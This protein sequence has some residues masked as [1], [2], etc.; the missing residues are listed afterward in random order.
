MR[1]SSTT[2]PTWETRSWTRTAPSSRSSSRTMTAKC[3]ETEVSRPA[4]AQHN[5]WFEVQIQNWPPCSPKSAAS[6]TTRSLWSWSVRWGNT[7]TTRTKTTRTSTTLTWT[8]WSCVTARTTAART[9][10]VARVSQPPAARLCTESTTL[11]HNAP[12]TG[13]CVACRTNQQRRQQEVS[14]RQDL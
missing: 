10:W 13:V 8:R 11:L 6:S 2:Y 1:R 5:F 3:T 12:I 9:G 7:A 4:A 14:L